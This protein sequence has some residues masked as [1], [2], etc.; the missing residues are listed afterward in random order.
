MIGSLIGKLISI[1]M[2][3][4]VSLE[5]TDATAALFTK[6][7]QHHQTGQM[8]TMY[9][10][11]HLVHIAAHYFDLNAAKCALSNLKNSSVTEPPM[12]SESHFSSDSGQVQL[13]ETLLDSITVTWNKSLDYDRRLF[14]VCVPSS[15]SKSAMIW[16][17]FV[18]Y[19]FIYGLVSVLERQS[20]I[21]HQSRISRYAILMVQSIAFS[22]YFKGRRLAPHHF[23]DSDLIRSQARW[24]A[25]RH[26]WNRTC[27]DGTSPGSLWLLSAR[28]SN[29]YFNR[30]EPGCFFFWMKSHSG[31][32][33]TYAYKP[34]IV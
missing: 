13:F 28:T 4:C 21:F 7:Q 18:Q 20:P 12:A 33:N 26:I 27:S 31:K 17:M 29:T 8:E 30:D 3:T 10:L 22:V 15:S 6:E 32:K 24:I 5:V 11:N 34:H 25:P 23:T 19:D 2:F 14:Q 16:A 1:Q 9:P